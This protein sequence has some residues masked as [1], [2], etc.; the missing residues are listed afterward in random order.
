M[1][2]LSKIVTSTLHMPGI[3]CLRSFST[4]TTCS[5]D[6]LSSLPS[7]TLRHWKNRGRGRGGQNLTERYRR[8]ENTFRGK[9]AFIKQISE[10][11]QEVDNASKTRSPPLIS[12]PHSDAQKAPDTIAGFVIP[13]APIP[14]A[15]EE[16]EWPERIRTSAKIPAVD[17]RQDAILSAFEEMEHQLKEKR[18]R[19]AAVQAENAPRESASATSSPLSPTTMTS[20]TAFKT[21][22]LANDI[23]EVSS[24]D[25]IYAFDVEANKRIN[26][27]APWDK[28]WKARIIEFSVDHLTLVLLQVIH[29]RS[30][31][32]HE[33]MGLMQGKVMGN[34]LVIMDSF[35]LPVQGTETR[36]NAANEANEYM[37]KYI[38]ESEKAKRLE[39]AIG[40]Y[41]SHPGYGCWL[42]GIDVDTQM[43]NQ[44]FQDPFVAVVI[45]P[46]R[47]ISA[48]K[49]DIGAFRTYP[50]NY[51]PP[52][53]AA[54]EYQSIPL[55]KIED[56][57][58]HANQYYP[59][60]VEVFKSSLDTELLGLL[61]NKYW[62]NTLSQ[63]PLISNRAYAVSQIVDL[64][65]KLSKAQASVS[66]TRAPIPT[67]KGQDEKTTN[68]KSQKEEKKK[69]D[70]QLA[71]GVKDSTKIAA[72]AQHGLIS[73]ILLSPSSPTSTHQEQ[74]NLKMG[75]QEY[76]VVGRHLPTANEPNPKIY[77]MRIFAPNEV[78]AKSRFWYFLRQL[79]KVK[80]ASGEVIG[81]N[82]IHEAK[83]LKV[84]N[85]GIWLRYDSRSG[86]HNMY[87]E[88][89]DLSR[90]DAV[91]SLY[92]DMAA[93]HR[94]RF[95]SIHILRVVEIAKADDVRRPYIKQLLTPNL[96]FP[97][98][99]RV[100]K[101]AATFVAHR[102]STF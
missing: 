101:T 82:V 89:R 91:K 100:G 13:Q 96:K 38:E 79:K 77:R 72:E 65:Q 80:K 74:V 28:E 51:T 70:N 62:V 57:G 40:W 44:Q 56:F 18:A 15:D 98:P 76:Q 61:W 39:N 30:G 24:Q 20:S 26:R 32:P 1:L 49:V 63:S 22:S 17:M 75:L 21:F 14:P 66:S 68:A 10:L 9:H 33:I 41:H 27:E 90:A 52:N 58:V 69:E 84:K 102:P 64:H 78:V 7:I 95:R 73:Q 11:S 46:N 55:S 93:R 86:T 47:T 8:L 81:V 5:S 36:V 37:V 45:D 43:N 85:F 48:G 34:S 42:S 50:S 4:N 25:E 92:Q 88:F 6:T 19:R 53:A 23:F 83:P 97:L 12:P 2:S 35:A 54:S 94:A 99:H 29:A 3:A 31:V 67:P 59:L 71:K 16:S 87:K 60:D